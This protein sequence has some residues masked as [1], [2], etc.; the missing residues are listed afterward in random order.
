MMNSEEEGGR[1]GSLKK[2]MQSLGVLRDFCVSR[3]AAEDDEDDEE[4]MMLLSSRE[5]GSTEYC[6]ME[7]M[8][9]YCEN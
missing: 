3:A 9:R 5:E 7:A 8:R 2:V 6:D 1:L 4:E